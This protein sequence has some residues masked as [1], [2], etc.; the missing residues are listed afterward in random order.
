MVFY[1][2]IKSIPELIVAD[3]EPCIYSRKLM[4]SFNLHLKTMKIKDSPI[5]INYNT[6]LN[7]VGFPVIDV[8]WVLEKTNQPQFR[9]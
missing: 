1:P 8:K 3:L 4:E 7:L 5:H 9:L 2:Q 6:G